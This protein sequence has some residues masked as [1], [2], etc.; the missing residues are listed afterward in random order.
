MF[1]PMLPDDAR[2]HIFPIGQ[3]PKENV[4][5]V[6]AIFDHRKCHGWPHGICIMTGSVKRNRSRALPCDLCSLWHLWDL[7]RPFLVLLCGHIQG[8]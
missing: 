1:Y 3:S 2:V 7:H 6:Y 4:C 5:M 8:Y